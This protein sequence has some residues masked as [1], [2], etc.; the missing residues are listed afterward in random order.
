MARK[1]ARTLSDQIEPFDRDD[2]A[3]W[4]GALRMA[5]PGNRQRCAT[6]PRRKRTRSPVGQIGSPGSLRRSP[7]AQ[8][9]RFTPRL[10]GKPICLHQIDSIWSDSALVGPMPPNRP[11][12]GPRRA[13]HA[14][15]PDPRLRPAKGRIPESRTVD[16]CRQLFDGEPYVNVD[17][18]RHVV[19]RG[20]RTRIRRAD[21]ISPQ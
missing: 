2:F 7:D 5:M 8:A 4:L 3:S 9:S 6:T 15:F 20:S 19:R 11:F 13:L 16:T 12:P 14:T 10:P 1:V 17:G 21:P 18:T